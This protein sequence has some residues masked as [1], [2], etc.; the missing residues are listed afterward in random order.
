MLLLG[1]DCSEQPLIVLLLHIHAR[2]SKQGEY[3]QLHLRGANLESQKEPALEYIQL[4]K[5]A[6][7][8]Y[9]L[10]IAAIDQSSLD[11]FASRSKTF[12]ESPYGQQLS[13]KSSVSTL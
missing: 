4:V 9:S 10:D 6:H 11:M 1:P 3:A 5:C 8:K 12:E 2:H 7:G 13:Q